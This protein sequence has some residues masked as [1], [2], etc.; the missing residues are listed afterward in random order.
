MRRSF[1]WVCAI[2]SPALAA[3]PTTEVELLQAYAE[4]DLARSDLD[5]AR[6]QSRSNRTVPT[7]FEN[8]ALTVAH[9][10]ARGPAGATTDV[11]GGEVTV[12]LGLSGLAYRGAGRAAKLSGEQRVAL[13]WLDG[14]CELRRRAVSAWATETLADAHRRTADRVR[15][16]SENLA[17]RADAGDASGYARDRLALEAAAIWLD[18]DTATGDADAE[19]ARL[20]AWIGRPVEQVA[21]SPLPPLPALEDLRV[22]L[23]AHPEQIALRHEVDA[24]KGTLGAAQRA[25]LPDLTLS[26]ASRWDALPDSTV[27][28]QGFEVGGALELPL[29]DWSRSSVR[30]AQAGHATAEADLRRRQADQLAEVQGAWHRV[31]ALSSDL[32]MP[33]PEAV[34]QGALQRFDAGETSLEALLQTAA[35]VQSGEVARIERERRLRLAHL[36]LSCSVGSFAVPELQTVLEESRP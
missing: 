35:G 23:D 19:R 11:I 29:F 12:D 20:E 30:A 7:L 3:G 2:S 8:P 10:E 1:V 18:A 21:L 28:S 26:A 5:A 32:A 4:S 25:A 17:S 13:T 6:A 9:E 36:D 31:A 33:S 22:E 15:T 24:A 16:L 14:A 27:A 34:W